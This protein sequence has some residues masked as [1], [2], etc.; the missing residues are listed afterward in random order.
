MSYAKQKFF[1]AVNSLVGPPELKKRLTY[2]A[3]HLVML[4]RGDLPADMRDDFEALKRELVRTP[5]SNAAGDTLGDLSDREA[6]GLAERILGMY[7]K[8]LGGL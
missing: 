1:E 4:S 7:T 6:T 3:G 8:L 2:A 5:L